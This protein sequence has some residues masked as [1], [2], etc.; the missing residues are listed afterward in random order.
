M[1]TRVVAAET[2]DDKR[3]LLEKAIRDKESSRSKSRSYFLPVKRRRTFPKPK[4]NLKRRVSGVLLVASKQLSFE[5]LGSPELEAYV[6]SAGAST[7][8]S[9][10][11]YLKVL[12]DVYQS[13]SRYLS[14]T[15]A[16]ASIRSFTYDG[17]SD[18]LGAPIAGMTFHFID[19][20]WR[21]RQYLLLCFLTHT[22]WTRQQPVMKQLLP[23]LYQTMIRLG[24]TCLCFPE[25]ATMS[26]V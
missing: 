26:P 3:K 24:R 6:S 10:K 9:K 14:S 12:P 19:K 8:K 13:L 15:T 25:Q 17:W 7:E 11:E 18:R 16:L 21:L 23:L 1:Y 4:S 20:Y 2:I 22:R 5:L